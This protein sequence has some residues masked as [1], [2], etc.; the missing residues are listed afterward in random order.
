MR[1][2][3]CFLL[4]GARYRPRR[5]C[6]AQRSDARS[7]AVVWF[8]DWRWLWGTEVLQGESCRRAALL[9]RTV[10]SDTVPGLSLRD[11]SGMADDLCEDCSGRIESQKIRVTCGRC[12]WCIGALLCK[13]SKMRSVAMRTG[14]VPASAHIHAHH[15]VMRSITAAACGQAGFC[16]RSRH[17]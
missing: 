9:A 4:I 16:V 8:S 12:L 14:D 17:R 1:E 11:A 3:K 10:L 2:F 7:C 13:Y 6:G 15:A 5:L